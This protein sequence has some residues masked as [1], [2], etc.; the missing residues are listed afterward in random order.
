MT[1]AFSSS[2]AMISSVSSTN[3]TGD[4]TDDVGPTLSLTTGESTAT[5][6]PVT[7]TY[8]I[9]IKITNRIYN[10]SLSDPNSTEY[11]NLRMEVESLF[12]RA[13]NGTGAHYQGVTQMMFSNGSV[14]AESTTQFETTD[15]NPDVILF[16]LNGKANSSSSLSL[17]DGFAKVDSSSSSPTSGPTAMTSS[18]DVSSSNTTITFSTKQPLEVNSTT[19]IANTTTHPATSHFMNISTVT[20]DTSSK[21]GTNNETTTTGAIVPSATQ[22][23]SSTQHSAG[24]N[25]SETDTSTGVPGWGI[26]LL[27]LAALILFILLI[28]LVFLVYFCCCRSGGRGFMNVSDPYMPFNPDIPMYS[29]HTTIDLPTNGKPYDNNNPKNRSGMYVVNPSVK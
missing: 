13:F 28:F 17:Q 26:A 21:N 9:S 16:E 8:L 22:Q 4:H 20:E 24:G 6:S 15:I 10:D 19:L 29:S 27:V 12:Q 25:A 3:T 23:S 14:I 2:T 7:T 5:S 18:T 1:A 11:K